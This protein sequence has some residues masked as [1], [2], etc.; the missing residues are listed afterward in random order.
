M[1]KHKRQQNCAKTAP[2]FTIPNGIT[3]E[4]ADI[5]QVWIQYESACLPAIRQMHDGTLNLHDV[6]LH[7]WMKKIS[8]KEDTAVIKQ[9][10]WYLFTVPGWFNTL[11]NATFSQECSCL[12]LYAH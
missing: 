10:L 9:Q 7:I 4:L 8:P 5:M 1:M 3:K 11:T 6:D 12:C 2:P